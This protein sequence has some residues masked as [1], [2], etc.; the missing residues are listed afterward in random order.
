MLISA[1]IVMLIDVYSLTFGRQQ[2]LLSTVMNP[3]VNSLQPRHWYKQL[4]WWRLHLSIPALEIRRTK[5]KF[6]PKQKKTKKNNNKVCGSVWWLF[7]AHLFWSLGHRYPIQYERK[8]ASS[9]ES[10][11]NHIVKGMSKRNLP[12]RCRRRSN[13]TPARV[14]CPNF[15]SIVIVTFESGHTSSIRLPLCIK[16]FF[17]P[18]FCFP[19]SICIEYL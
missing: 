9:R 13:R 2:Q 3:L 17:S 7:V 19:T 8:W 14:R 4:P 5:T 16:C 18:S 1:Y 12:S 10:S 15:T 6:S 11:Y